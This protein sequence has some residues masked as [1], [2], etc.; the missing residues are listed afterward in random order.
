[1][2]R[3][4]RFDVIIHHRHHHPHGWMAFVIAH[5][6]SHSLP[7]LLC[8]EASSSSDRPMP[9]LP[10][11]PLMISIFCNLFLLCCEPEWLT[12]MNPQRQFCPNQ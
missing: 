2:G 10:P 7:C 4:I 11:S 8:G 9:P 3:P 6:I 5:H 12:P 1:M